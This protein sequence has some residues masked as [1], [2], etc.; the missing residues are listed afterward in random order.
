MADETKAMKYDA[1]ISYRHC[2]LDQFVAINLHR[3]L[4][5]FKLPKSALG[6]LKEGVNGKIE[7]VF[8]DEDELPL[9]TNLSDPIE[10]ALT[11]SD[12]LIVICT[13][14]LKL[15]SWCQKEIETFIQL[16]G[17]DKILLVLAEGEPADSFPEIMTYEEVETID[18]DGNKVLTRKPLEP[19]AADVRGKNNKERLKAMDNAVIKLV[20]AMKGLNYDDIKQRHKEQKMKA[21]VRFW[22]SVSV[23]IMIFALVCLGMLAKINSQ[24]NVIQDK[25][26]S[27]MANAAENLLEAGRRQDAL[28][29][30]KTVLPKNGNY[31][32]ESYKMLTT[33][34]S[35]YSVGTSYIPTKTFKAQAYVLDYIVSDNG[36]FI[37]LC[38]TNNNVT[39]YNTD[40]SEILAEFEM[41][42]INDGLPY[43]NFDNESGFVYRSE[44]GM[45]YFN[46]QTKEEFVICDD[47][48][49]VLAGEESD[50]LIVFAN[51]VIYGFRDGVNIYETNL[52]EL[53]V[54][55]G[56]YYDY[57]YGYSSDGKLLSVAMRGYDVK[58]LIFVVE[59]ENGNV[60]SALKYRV[61]GNLC[62]AANE[63]YIYLISMGLDSN[64]SKLYIIDTDTADIYGSIDVPMGFVK[65]IKFVNDDVFLIA[66]YSGMI[67]DS[68]N[69]ETLAHA[70]QCSLV[71]SGFV[72]GDTAYLVDYSGNVFELSED[73]A[74][75]MD[76]TLMMFDINTQ[77][78]VEKVMCAGD[79]LFYQF[80]DTNYITLYEDN[81]DMAAVEIPEGE[82]GHKED[83]ESLDLTDEEIEKIV[84]DV[85]LQNIYAALYSSDKRYVLVTMLDG[86]IRIYDAKKHKH[87]KTL[88]SVNNYLV[89]SFAHLKED[90]IYV[91]NV[92]PYSYVL[93]ENLE[94][95]SRLDYVEG[96][97]DHSFVILDNTGKYYKVPYV[98]YKEM[99]KKA[100]EL[101]KDYEPDEEMIERYGMTE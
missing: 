91:V 93:N 18:A 94:I 45:K 4:E 92:Y 8:R 66:S 97:E 32:A 46:L 24:K 36:T 38:D 76:V 85:K 57:D 14:R 17:R 13:P 37:A 63:D 1:F 3:K 35:P 7:R 61:D 82:F 90:N 28:Y 26:A 2:E 52:D 33:A 78:D 10:L 9:A 71:I 41:S 88:Y 60:R 34:V 62:V 72:K 29:A 42:F 40:T 58:S 96:Y 75:G 55:T 81:P 64:A 67:I 12:Y 5:K 69:F 15:S 6:L 98:P 25:Y 51:G 44:E 56:D 87:I 53:G 50:V 79:K 22:S 27:S 59:T 31:N 49:Y 95:I 70:D 74:Y 68:E 48:G 100:D 83:F 23:A 54:E 73:Y 84:T 11:N 16:H 43:C 77:N 89:D 86:S 101:L 47:N 19:L 99:L 39:I 30:V 65:D 21:L 80:Y 20:A